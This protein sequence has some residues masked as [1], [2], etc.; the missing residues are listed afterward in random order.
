VRDPDKATLWTPGFTEQELTMEE[1]TGGILLRAKN[2]FPPETSAHLKETIPTAA[3]AQTSKP[4][5]WEA[6]Q[7]FRQKMEIDS[8]DIDTDIFNL[9]ATDIGRE[10]NL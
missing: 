6:L 10:V 4:T 5:L 8:L 9:R 3:S 2:P 7:T 1:T